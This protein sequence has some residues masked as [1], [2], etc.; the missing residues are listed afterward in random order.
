MVNEFKSHSAV[1]DR[2]DNVSHLVLFDF[3]NRHSQVGRNPR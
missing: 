1:K 2:L 3:A